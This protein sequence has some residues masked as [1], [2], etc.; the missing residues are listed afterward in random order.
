MQ[1]EKGKN[2]MRFWKFALFLSLIV[3]MAGCSLPMGQ[4]I[5]MEAGAVAEAEEDWYF[6]GFVYFDQVALSVPMQDVYVVLYLCS[7]T[8]SLSQKRDVNVFK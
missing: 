2:K 8:S 4:D 5:E 6:S 1:S 3:F 7:I